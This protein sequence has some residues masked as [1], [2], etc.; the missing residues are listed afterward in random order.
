MGQCKGWTSPRARSIPRVEINMRYSFVL[1]LISCGLATQTATSQTGV[2]VVQAPA[3]GRAFEVASIKPAPPLDAMLASGRIHLGAKIDDAIVDIGGFSLLALIG[4]AYSLQPDQISGPDWMDSARFD[5]MAKMPAGATREQVPEMLQT[6]LADRF[7][8]TVHR[9]KKDQPVYALLVGKDGPKLTPSLPG[10]D[11][12]SGPPA[13]EEVDG[14]RGGTVPK[15]AYGAK[16]ISVTNGDLHVEFTQ[17]PL[18][19]L[20]ESLKPYLGRPVVDMTGLRGTYQVTLD[21][22]RADMLAVSKAASIPE[23]AAADSGNAPVTASDPPGNSILS[24]LRRYGL[25]LEPRKA[26]VEYLV[27][28]HLEKAPT[29]N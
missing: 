9:E 25:R 19:A 15:S 5:I 6:L 28:D 26:P 8:L 16:N 29:A 27:V 14:G 4:A 7:K 13:K 17:M 23:G 1:F 11:A 24:A 12:T 22:S 21:F 18:T 3:A 2:A 10:A 20:A